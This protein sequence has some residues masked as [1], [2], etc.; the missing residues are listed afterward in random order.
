LSSITCSIDE[1]Q[2]ATVVLNRPDKLNAI[3]MAMFQGVNTMIRELKKN[4]E[5]RVVIVKGNGADFCSGL[6]VKSL[7]NSKAGALKLLFKLWPTLPNAAQYFSIGWR[8]IPCPVI[9]AIHGRCSGGGLQLVS[10]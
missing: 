2:I 9:F 1:N 8:Y 6:D 5:I 3:D 4:T 7:L 10:G